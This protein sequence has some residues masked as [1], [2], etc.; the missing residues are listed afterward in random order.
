MCAA[1][2]NAANNAANDCSDIVGQNKKNTYL[3]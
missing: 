3:I 1:A 2:A